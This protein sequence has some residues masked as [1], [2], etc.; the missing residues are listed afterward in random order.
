MRKFLFAFSILLISFCGMAYA[1]PD[2]EFTP[3]EGGKYIYSNNREFIFRQDLA[4]V[5]N[6]EPRFI[7]SNENMGADKYTLFASHVN[8]TEEKDRYGIIKDKGF[9]VELDVMFRAKED[10]RVVITAMGFEVPE[11]IKYYI[12]REEFTMEKDWGCFTAWASYLGTE[13][14]KL[15]S[16]EKYKPIPFEATEFT[17]K[18]GEIVYLS[19]FIPNYRAVPIWRPVHIITDFEIVSGVCDINVLAVKSRGTPGNRQYVNKNA[20]FGSFVPQYEMK[21]VANSQ[22]QVD[23]Y[24]DFHVPGWYAAGTKLPVTVYNR[25]APQGKEVTTWYTNLNPTSDVWNKDNVAESCMLAFQYKDPSKKGYY[26]NS[27]KEEDRD[28]IWRFDT[29]HALLWEYKPGIGYTRWNFKPNFEITGYIPEDYCNSLGNYGVMQNY[30]VTVTNEGYSDRWLNYCLNTAANNLIIL[31][32]EN[33]KIMP[34]YPLTKGTTGV[35]ESDK[36]INI[37]LPA[38]ETVK[39]TLTV[40]LTTNHVGG[41]ENS[42]VINDMP[43]PIY[44]YDADFVNNVR[45]MSYTGKEYISYDNGKLYVSED[46]ESWSEMWISPEVRRIFDNSGELTLTWTGKGYIA[47]NRQHSGIP[48][49]SV[50]EFYREVWGLNSDFTLAW[51]TD[52]GIYPTESSGAFDVYYIKAGSNYYSTDG[53]T[54]NLLGGNMNLPR[55]NYGR[56]AASSRRGKICLSEDG[57]IFKDVVY[58]GKTPLYIDAL[59]DV[60]YYISGKDIYLSKEGVYWEKIEAPT[61]IDKLGRKGDNLQGDALPGDALQGDALL[62]NGNIEI[63]LPELEKDN[64]V[65]E[66]DGK[67]LG[68]EKPPTNIDGIYYV[69]LRSFVELIGG[70]LAWNSETN[71]A[72]VTVGAITAGFTEGENNVIIQNGIML[73]PAEDINMLEK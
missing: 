40:I 2:L 18:A 43:S 32:D 14:S 8:H 5:T 57:I 23:A 67:Y 53:K 7:M 41:M 42:F 34:G 25:Y 52:F 55:Y 17:V 35:K 47:N 21:G 30:H 50:R 37:K 19:R 54:W 38:Q 39:F 24:I 64:Y 58:E 73:V 11:N 9:D 22:N 13:I 69:P 62:V 49:Y 60:Y 59:G 70:S 45:D 31:R 10:T 48:Y 68:F 26:G 16:G 51:K 33:G 36:L 65:V 29:N 61:Q 4:D 44:T 12:D 71:T 27:V 20:A 15:D 72:E 1:A 6:P 56:F 46:G 28:D 3:R 66:F 63:P